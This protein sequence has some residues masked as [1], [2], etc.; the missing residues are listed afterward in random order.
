M[1][2]VLGYIFGYLDLPQYFSFLGNEQFKVL[3]ALAS[4][5]LTSTVAISI[6][7]IKER[8]PQLDPRTREDDGSTGVVTFFKQTFAS[9]KRLPPQTRKVCQIQFFGWMGWF[10]FLFYITTYIG[11]LYVNPHLHS[12]LTKEEVDQLW[13]KATRI[14]TLALLVYAIVSFAANIFLPFLVLPTYQPS[15]SE[16]ARDLA[17]PITPTSPIAVMSRNA[18]W[19]E[20][21]MA[22]AQS[23]HNLPAHVRDETNLSVSST[24]VGPNFMDRALAHLQIPGFTLRRAWMLAQLLFSACMFATFFIST[25]L[26]ASI[27]TAFVGLSWALTLWA[28]FALISAEIA[29]RDESRRQRQRQKLQMDLS[30]DEEN[31]R[32]E[33]EEDKAGIILGL[34]NVAISSPQVLATLIS[35]AVFKALQKP[36]GVPGDTS[37]GWTLRIGGVTTLVAAF[38]TWQMPE[39]NGN[40]EEE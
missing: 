13:G 1:G 12:G 34:H 29:K 14:G 26:A 24:L 20:M 16:E 30:G 23:Q 25:P 17:R 36:R 2:N 35:S 15:I 9:I 8:N 19:G 21:A 10:P 31:Q 6:F 5:I 4:I 18:S 33:Q 39:A 11:Q 32:F 7:S 38:L 3:C 37:V 40:G 22:R 27:M 28:P